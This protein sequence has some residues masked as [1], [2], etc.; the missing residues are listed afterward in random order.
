[1]PVPNVV[2]R[3]LIPEGRQLKSVELLRA[4]ETAAFTIEGAYAVITVP[5]V[6]IA[7]IVH[8]RFA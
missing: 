8:L 6:H 5:T 2:A 3:V 7:E 1:M 4:N